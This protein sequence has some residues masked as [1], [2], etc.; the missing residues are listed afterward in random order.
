MMIRSWRLVRI[1]LVACAFFTTAAGTIWAATING[2]ALNDTLRGTSAADKLYGRAGNDRLQGVAGN[3]LLVGGPGNDV[4]VGGPGRDTVQCGAGRDRVSRDIQDKVAKDCEVI[5][6][7]KPAPPAPP[8]PPSPP[9]PTPPPPSPITAG[10]YKGLLEGNFVF[11]DVSSNRT[12][13]GFRSNYLREDCDGDIY[14]Y[15]TLDWG[16]TAYPIANDGTFSFSANSQ[17]TIGDGT[18][19]FYDEV[20]GRIDG[21]TATGTVVG[22]AEF[23]YQ[24]RHWKCTSGRRTWTATLQP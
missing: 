5:R 10:S 22:T 14:V 21:S 8:L 12:V 3:D 6:G 7:P 4:L 9:A 24:G 11:F 16:S 20:T 1:A 19:T 2:T 13:S 18:G 17:G 15:G 23:D